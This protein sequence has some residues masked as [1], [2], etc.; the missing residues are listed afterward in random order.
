[1]RGKARAGQ[2]PQTTSSCADRV[3]ESWAQPS[4]LVHERGAELPEPIEHCLTGMVE[5][6]RC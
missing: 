5:W 3:S 1:M 2:L 6:C 4:R